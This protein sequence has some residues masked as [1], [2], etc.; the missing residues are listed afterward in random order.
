MLRTYK[1]RLKDNRVEWIDEI[2]DQQTPVQVYVTVLEEK[3]ARA[4]PSRGHMMAESLKQLGR[5]GA[6]SD[7]SDAETW[8]RQIRRDRQLPIRND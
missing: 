2:P 4:I 8:Q 3:S 1:A 7:I 5:I 6:F